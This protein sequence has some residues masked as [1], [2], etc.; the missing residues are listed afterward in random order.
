M[1]NFTLLARD[2]TP[3]IIS[4][5]KVGA[6]FRKLI[7]DNDVLASMKADIGWC[8][9]MVC[10]TGS[11]IKSFWEILAKSERIDKTLVDIGVLRY[12]TKVNPYFKVFRI[13]LR[14][15]AYSSRIATVQSDDN[16]VIGEYECQKYKAC[17]KVIDMLSE[18]STRA[19][20]LQTERL[21]G[22]GLE[23]ED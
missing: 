3:D 2:G 7:G 6:W 16:G 23:E 18:K 4:R 17:G 9:W 20:A 13:K 22:I 8:E 1:K 5:A 10:K 14:V 11:E 15:W 12:P 19:A 21:L